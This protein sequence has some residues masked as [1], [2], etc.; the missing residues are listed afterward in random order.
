MPGLAKTYG[1]EK[2]TAIVNILKANYPHKQT[3]T[4]SCM[5]SGRPGLNG[6]FMRNNVVKM[7]GFKHDLH[8]PRLRLLFH[9]ANSAV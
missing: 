2:A 4:L 3:A 9:L 8:A 7:C 1:E 5:C 6:L